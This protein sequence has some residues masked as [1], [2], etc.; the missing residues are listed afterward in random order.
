MTENKQTHDVFEGEIPSDLGK[1]S[2]PIWFKVI[3]LVAMVGVLGT[4]AF[5]LERDK[6]YLVEPGIDITESITSIAEPES[7]EIELGTDDGLTPD[8]INID[9]PSAQDVDGET[10]VDLIA[11]ENDE[12]AIVITPPAQSSSESP[13]SNSET[14]NADLQE[15]VS[16]ISSRLDEIEANESERIT[17]VRSGIEL[18]AQSVEKLNDLVRSLD[19][20]KKELAALKTAPVATGPKPASNKQATPQAA[21]NIQA[22]PTIPNK[23]NELNLIGIDSWG[24]ERFAQIEYSGEIHLLASNETIGGWRLESIAKDSVVVE[25][26]EGES[27]ELSI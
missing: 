8:P 18:H 21:P 24:G 25:N 2:A 3:G 9:I 15:E 27:F 13:I 1:K 16:Q 20:L 12:S 4:A 23:T 26:Q 14:L 10:E 6:D 11:I 7:T 19:D 17:V 5:L 22:K